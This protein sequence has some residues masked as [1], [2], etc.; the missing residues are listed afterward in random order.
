MLDLYLVAKFI[1]ISFRQL[2]MPE[3]QKH[4]IL[5]MK[6]CFRFW[7]FRNYAV[8]YLHKTIK[9]GVS[10]ALLLLLQAQIQHVSK[11]SI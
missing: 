7:M 1:Y 3:K 4:I 8:L 9:L 2:K 5:Y 11:N 6:I 10:T